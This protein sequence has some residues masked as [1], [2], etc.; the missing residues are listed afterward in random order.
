M[1]DCSLSLAPVSNLGKAARQEGDV[2][3]QLG[4]DLV[5]AVLRGRQQVHEQRGEAALPQSGGDELIA[6]AEAAASAAMDKDDDAERL[7]GN[8]EQSAHP[9]AADRYVHIAP[10]R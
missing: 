1:P 10:L 9:S 8:T 6:R 4:C 5:N 7:G 3:T 2:E